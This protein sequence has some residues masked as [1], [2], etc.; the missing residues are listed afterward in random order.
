MNRR[1]LSVIF[2]ILGLLVTSY[3]V[4]AAPTGPSNIIRGA[5]QRAGLNSTEK[6]QVAEAGNMTALKVNA[7]SITARWQG[8][9]GNIT[10]EFTL[11]DASNN[12]LYNWLIVTVQGE[13]YASNGTNVAWSSIDCANF[14]A[15][16]KEKNVNLSTLNTLIGYA[17]DIEQGNSDSVNAT[18]NQ[19]YGDDASTFAV[20]T[21]TINNADNC[22]MATLFV[23]EV[24]QTARF[25]EVLLT[26]NISIIFTALLEQDQTG[27]SG[28]TL[29]FEMIVGVN[30]S[31]SGTTKNYYF[32]V[33]LT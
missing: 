17:S 32:Y 30:G 27:F 7:T 29:D 13:I 16:G 4:S 3:I 14:S 9:Y 12:T 26:D 20:G 5:S 21:R 8:F 24:Y 6:T 23:N 22:S 10:G 11:D 1:N 31:Q 25:K 19:T 15:N 2:F 33:E 18:F 28:S